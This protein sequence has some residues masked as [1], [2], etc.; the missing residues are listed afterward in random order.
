MRRFIQHKEMLL[1]GL[2]KPVMVSI[3]NLHMLNPCSR[4]ILDLSLDNLEFNALPSGLHLVDEDVVSVV[5]FSPP[6]PPDFVP[7][8]FY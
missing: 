4:R 8:L 6:S 3:F 5:S 1:T 2:R 7:Q